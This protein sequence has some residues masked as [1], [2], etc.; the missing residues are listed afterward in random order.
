MKY[1]ITFYCP[2]RHIAYEGGRLPDEKGIGGGINARIRIAHALAEIGHDVTMICFCAQE[3]IDRGVHYVPLDKI[4]RVD[5]DIL[6]LTT[7]GDKLSL[8]PVVEMTI[9]AKLRVLLIHGPWKPL[10]TEEASPDYFYPPTNFNNRVIQTEWNGIPPEKTFV[11]YR[12]I[13][14]GYFKTDSPPH[15]DPFRLVSVGNPQKGRQAA[16][17]VLKI[18]RQTDTRYHLYAFGD[19]GLWG[20]KTG[21]SIPEDG[22]KYFGTIGQRVLCQQLVSASYGVFLQSY[23]EGFANA[24]VQTMYAGCIPLGSP[25]GAIEEHIHHAQNG[26]LIEGSNDLPET[27]NK[28]SETIRYLQENQDLVLQLRKNAQAWPLRW[29]QIALSWEQHWDVVL[30]NTPS[31][32]YVS[33]FACKICSNLLLHLAD[34]YHCMECGRFYKELP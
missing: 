4:S 26:F 18:L 1:R 12:G 30:G 10:G 29:G 23:L 19:E 20:G 34:G 7:S 22:V 27:W 24:L 33:S 25:I 2:D 6:V 15:R 32:L 9:S 21:L 17:E 3:E 8:L 16:I 31:E 5:T 14:E 13:T 11:S 28:T